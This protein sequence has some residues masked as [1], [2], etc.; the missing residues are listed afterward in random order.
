[1]SLFAMSVMATVVILGFIALAFWRN[2]DPCPQCGSRTR[3]NQLVDGDGR[4]AD[5]ECGKC[6]H[7]YVPEW[8]ARARARGE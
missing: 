5:A 1:M 7:V 3:A 8:I 2:V 4:F 6:G